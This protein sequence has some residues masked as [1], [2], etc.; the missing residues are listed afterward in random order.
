ME[1]MNLNRLNE[2]HIRMALMKLYLVFHSEFNTFLD[3]IDEFIPYYRHRLTFHH[4]LSLNGYNFGVFRT[5]NSRSIINE[6]H[7]QQ[8]GR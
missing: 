8:K 2:L 7:W 3:V 6:S 4:G 5:E 1:V